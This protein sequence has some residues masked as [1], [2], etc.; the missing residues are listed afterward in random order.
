MK[1]ALAKTL[2]TAALN[3]ILE[4]RLDAMDQMKRDRLEVAPNDVMLAPDVLVHNLLIHHK[5]TRFATWKAFLNLCTLVESFVLNDNIVV[6]IPRKGSE[7]VIN[8]VFLGVLQRVI[9]IPVKEL[10]GVV[11]IGIGLAK[12]D[13]EIIYRFPDEGVLERQR[14]VSQELRADPMFETERAVFEEVIANGMDAVVHLGYEE[15]ATVLGCTYVAGFTGGGD[16]YQKLT[17]A[18]IQSLDRVTPRYFYDLVKQSLC[19]EVKNLRMAGWHGNLP[20]PPLALLLFRRCKGEKSHL[21]EVLLEERDK[22]KSF[23]RWVNEIRA[24]FISTQSVQKAARLHRSLQRVFKEFA[25]T[26]EAESWKVT[27]WNGL[28][29]AFPKDVWDGLSKK[30]IDVKSLASFLASR[31]LQMIA[32]LVQQRNYV[33]LLDVRD[34]VRRIKDYAS[35]LEQLL[36]ARMSEEDISALSSGLSWGGKNS[37]SAR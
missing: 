1:P 24:E 18:R 31:P 4:T 17:S 5:D 23:R 28:L 19:D 34:K 36:G 3:D 16:Y 32:K 33:Y 30:D 15:L 26:T 8:T 14:M 21:G 7:V 22:A 11:K 6:R 29:A 10:T 12:P 27:S 13:S 25:G 37:E 35:V 2:W 9:Q 20:I